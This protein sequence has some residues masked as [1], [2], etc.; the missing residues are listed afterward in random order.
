MT[1]VTTNEPAVR[2]PHHTLRTVCLL[3]VLNGAVL[4]AAL[5]DGG[6][7]PLALACVVA[8][9]TGLRCAARRRYAGSGRW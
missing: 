8:L 2:A 6:P 3:A 7:V 9:A 5:T 4:C 1:G